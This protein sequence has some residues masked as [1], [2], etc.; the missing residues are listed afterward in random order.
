MGKVGANYENGY[1]KC[2]Q[3]SKAHF[4][5]D[6]I[7]KEIEKIL[8]DHIV[9]DNKMIAMNADKVRKMPLEE[10][11]A[12]IQSPCKTIKAATYPNRNC[13]FNCDECIEE[14]LKEKVE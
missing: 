11:I 13:T 5:K 9:E 4:R 1:M 2:N 3:D 6:E 14:W 7:K 10:L 8:E 12:F